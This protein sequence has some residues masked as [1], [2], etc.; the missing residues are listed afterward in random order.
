VVRTFSVLGD[1]EAARHWA[2][3]ARA[4]F[5]ADPRFRAGRS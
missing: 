2:A 1:V 3:R 5:P 4:R